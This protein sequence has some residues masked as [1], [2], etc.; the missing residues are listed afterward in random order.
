MRRPPSPVIAT[1][2]GAP[3][4][5]ATSHSVRPMAMPAL[6]WIGSAA[7]C[8]GHGIGVSR[9]RHA[10]AIA[11]GADQI[12]ARHRAS[13][14]ERRRLDAQAFAEHG[15][16]IEPLRILQRKVQAAAPRERQRRE[17]RDRHASATALRQPIHSLKPENQPNDSILRSSTST[18]GLRHHHDPFPRCDHNSERY[19]TPQLLSEWTSPCAAAIR[20]CAASAP[21]R[22]AANRSP[23]SPWPCW[24]TT[25]RAQQRLHRR[26]RH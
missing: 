2:S 23:Q 5:R 25:P 9:R 14:R 22:P 18:K 1:L 26:P 6:P 24:Q 11:F 8:D 17:Q 20:P 7:P 16:P 19:L 12:S 4:A 10:R 15:R 3:A 13:V 21:A